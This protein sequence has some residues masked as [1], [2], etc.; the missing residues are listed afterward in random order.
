[1]KK[2]LNFKSLAMIIAIISAVC[3]TSCT[4]EPEGSKTDDEGIDLEATFSF[5]ATKTILEAYNITAT[6]LID[7]EIYLQENIS[8]ELWRDGINAPGINASKISCKVVAT[9]KENLPEYN[10]E[11]TYILE[12]SSANNVKVT[13]NNKTINLM[14]TKDKSVVSF[15][16]NLAGSKIPDYVAKK[17]TINIIDV[18]YQLQ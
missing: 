7:D 16:E 18:E 5:D 12:I 13:K 6:I 8:N 14:P 3:F 11:E 1:M 15:S 2:V 17:Q 9:A 4:P 10:T